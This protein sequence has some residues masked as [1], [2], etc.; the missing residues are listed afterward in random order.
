VV[1]EP[2]GASASLPTFRYHPDPVAAG[3]VV[4]SEIVCACCRQLRQYAYDGPVYGDYDLDE[5][6]CPWCIADGS[7]AAT[8][9]ASFTGPLWKVP[10]DVSAEADD[11]ILHRT[12]GFEG[13]QQP[14]WLHHCGDAAQ[15]CGA[16][17]AAELAAFPDAV[18]SLRHEHDGLGWTVDAV[19]NYIQSLDKDG[20]PTAYLFRCSACG[21]YL[22][23]SDFD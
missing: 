14:H 13:W 21:T 7:A 8:F 19:E 12:P 16:V 18:E 17:G 1:T 9:G 20:A 3:S 2:A 11:V 22:A 6:L 4:I 23:Y 10:E 15:Y 5:P